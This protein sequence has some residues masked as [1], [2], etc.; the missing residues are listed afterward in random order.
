MQRIR[1]YVAVVSLFAVLGATGTAIAARRNDG[2]RVPNPPSKVQNQQK[3]KP[4][5]W[6]ATIL[7]DLLDKYSFPPG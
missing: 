4:K 5:G 1:R 6:I 7:D 2:P 3:S